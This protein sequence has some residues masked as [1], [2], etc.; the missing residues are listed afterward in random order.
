MLK[1]HISDSVGSI[2]DSKKLVYYS[3]KIKNINETL[4]YKYIA[5]HKIKKDKA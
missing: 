2:I 3:H 1:D 4:K 5:L